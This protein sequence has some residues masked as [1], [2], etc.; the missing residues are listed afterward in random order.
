[1][2]Q[3]TMVLAAMVIF[4][5]LGCEKRAGQSEEADRYKAGIDGPT[6]VLAVGADEN[7]L[8]DQKKLS[9]QAKLDVAPAMDEG[10]GTGEDTGPEDTTPAPTTSPAPTPVPENES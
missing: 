4:L 3:L 9:R 10:N 8:K 6:C 7:L 2:K 5:A 1:M